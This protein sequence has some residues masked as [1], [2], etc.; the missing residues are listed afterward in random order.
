MSGSDKSDKRAAPTP[1]NDNEKV[2]KACLDNFK[3][4]EN[5]PNSLSSLQRNELRQLLGNEEEE[6]KEGTQRGRTR[7]LSS[8]FGNSNDAKN[9]WRNLFKQFRD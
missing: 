2:T 7:S 6:D 3:S 5:F 4:Q 1:Q 9:K 8:L